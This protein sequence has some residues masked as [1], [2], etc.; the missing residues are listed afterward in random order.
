MGG[1]MRDND[2]FTLSLLTNRELLCLNQHGGMPLQ[3][4][5]D[6]VKAAWMNF[7]GETPYVALFNLGEEPAVISASQV[8]GEISAMIEP[9]GAKIYKLKK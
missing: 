4:F 6:E 2:E 5:R 7:V 9:H 1:E 3:L 8:K